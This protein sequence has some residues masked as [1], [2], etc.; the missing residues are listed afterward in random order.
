MATQPTLDPLGLWREML[1]QWERGLNTVAN[2]AAGSSEFS[3]A[4]HQATATGL[5]MQ[6]AAGEAM[7]KALAA[8]N[9]PSRNDIL[10]LHERL[11]RIEAAIERLTP[12]PAEAPPAAATPRT[13]RPPG[14]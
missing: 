6:Q 11:G 3:R 12:A 10:A 8:L 13:R 4:M 5:R 9:L 14:A 7:E 2:E 1:G